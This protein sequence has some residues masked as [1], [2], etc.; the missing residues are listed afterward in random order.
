MF[1]YHCCKVSKDVYTGVD[2]TV[3][4]FGA[5]VSDGWIW[6]FQNKFLMILGP[7]YDKY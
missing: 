6:C 1:R 5:S 4:G 3:V 2:V 7:T